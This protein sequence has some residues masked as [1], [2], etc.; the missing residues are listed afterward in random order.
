MTLKVSIVK[1]FFVSI[2]MI[3]NVLLSFE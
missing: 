1:E 3:K 2:V